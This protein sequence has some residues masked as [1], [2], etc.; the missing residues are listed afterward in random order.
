MFENESITIIA[1]SV[2]FIL[3]AVTI[4]RALLR[5]TLFPKVPLKE[6]AISLVAGTGV[7][8]LIVKV[9]VLGIL[10]GVGLIVFLLGPS[11]LKI[12]PLRF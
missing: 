10:A 9:P 7:V 4:G 8:Y 1:I 2:G 12:K 11:L 3:A 5:R 6:F